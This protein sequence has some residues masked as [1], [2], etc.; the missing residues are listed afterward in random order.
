MTWL[1]AL[2]SVLYYISLPFTIVLITIYNGIVIALAPAL[3]LGHYLLSGLL[4]PLTL[5]AKFEV[6]QT[7]FFGYCA[8]NTCKT[9]YIYLGVAAVIGLLTGS[10]LHMSSSLLVSIFN[11]TPTPEETGRAA[12]S[13]RAAR[14][15]KKLEQA[16]QSSTTKIQG[17]N[18][19]DDS[20]TEKKFSEW[21]ETDQGLLR[22]TIL[23]ED[24][25]S[26]E[27]F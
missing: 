15:T 8:D 22:Q 6:G 18:W 16:W 19:K 1:S 3:H 23:E 2:G 20:S 24:D 7:P 14:E 26:E 17:G 11:L 9:L 25:D 13:V 21:L 12:A 5:L 10:I 27:G 4:L